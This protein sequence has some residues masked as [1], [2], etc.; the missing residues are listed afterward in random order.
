MKHELDLTARAAIKA[1]RL[2]SKL[3]QQKTKEA[4]NIFMKSQ[5]EIKN[6]VKMAEEASV[7]SHILA[8]EISDATDKMQD[9]L[10]ELQGTQH[11]MRHRRVHRV[12]DETMPKLQQIPEKHSEINEQAEII[13]EEEANQNTNAEDPM[14]E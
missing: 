10:K 4:E 3:I 12:H 11:R 1:R 5:E 9:K 14:D 8:K 2:E 13:H 7:Q 6:K